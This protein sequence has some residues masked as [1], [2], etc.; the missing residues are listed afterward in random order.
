MHKLLNASVLLVVF[1]TF[2]NALVYFGM[3]IYDSVQ[4]YIGIVNNTILYPGVSL[5]EAMDKFLIGFVFIIFSV[6]LAE[7]FLTEYSFLKKYQLPWL[8]LK[9][10]HQL[11]ILLVSAILVA[12]FVAWIPYA[13]LFDTEN[14][15]M[16]WSALIF[17]VS[18]LIM[19]CA[20][21][22]MKDLH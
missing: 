8:E 1:I 17:P 3:G 4:V 21:R 19:V 13:P 20:A 18:L 2:F 10:F 22:L 14:N 11:K 16:D 12:L 5:V 15:H 9:S 6:G 7:L